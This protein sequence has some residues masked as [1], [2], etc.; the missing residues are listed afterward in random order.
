MQ[1]ALFLASS[2]IHVAFFVVLIDLL[3]WSTQYKPL[4]KGLLFFEP[5]C[6]LWAVYIKGFVVKT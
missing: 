1:I 2:L 5:I 3:A 4:F 6:K